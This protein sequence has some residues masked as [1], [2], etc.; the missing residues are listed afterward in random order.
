MIP[1][2]L[3]R[4]DLL[5]RLGPIEPTLDSSGRRRWLARWMTHPQNPL[6]ARVMVNRIWQWV[7][8]E[9]LVAT[10]NDFG[11][12]GET[13]SHPLLLD[14]LASEFIASGWSVKHVVRLLAGS[15][16]FTQAS[17]WNPQ[18]TAVDLQNRLLW[19]WRPRRLEAEAVRDSMLAVSG[20]L[21]HS[22]HGPSMFPRIPD[23][24]LAGQSRPGLDW[25]E[26]DPE[27]NLRRSVYIFV[28]R[29]L[30]VP[31][32]ELLDSPDTTSSCEQRRVST[33]GPQALTFLNGDFAHEQAR[34]LAGRVMRATG[35]ERANQGPGRFP[36]G[37]GEGTEPRGIESGVGLSS[38]PGRADPGGYDRDSDHP[39]H[40]G[41]GP[42]ILLPDAVEHQRVLLLE[43]R[44][45]GPGAAR[46]IAGRG[47]IASEPPKK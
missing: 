25:G 37:I 44:F 13:P 23:S 33:T 43:L 39:G 24:V 17:D 6:V 34:R 7:F 5:A 12:A 36:D 8:G 4:P 40:P 16:T 9:G 29:S 14:Y 1:T 46:P 2:I 15:S 32:L 38:G 18:A 19:R 3:G 28:K 30:A 26:P 21:N 20:S 27:Q 10:E 41:A 45:T 11:V 22:M 42:S 31:E 47:E 35:E